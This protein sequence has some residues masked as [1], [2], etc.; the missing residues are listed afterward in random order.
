MTKRSISRKAFIRIALLGGIGVGAVYI[1]QRTVSYGLLNFLHWTIRGQL[2]KVKPPAIVGLSKCSSYSEDLIVYLR[3]LWNLSEMPD[4]KGKT[5][6]LKPNLLDE[7]ANNNAITNSR[8]IQ[9]VIALLGEKGVQKI[10]V[11][12]GSAF[13]RDTSSVVESSG[14]A[15]ILSSSGIPYS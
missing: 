9:A 12:D 15:E 6:L 13:R 4:L 8:I 5:I 10:T 11:G 1:Q 3:N 2:Q 14:L 7:I